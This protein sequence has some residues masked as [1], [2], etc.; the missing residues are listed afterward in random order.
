MRNLFSLADPAHSDCIEFNDGKI[1]LCDFRSLTEIN[2]DRLLE[3]VGSHTIDA[4]LTKSS[5]IGAVNW[6]KLVNVGTIWENIAVRLSQLGIPPKKVIFFMDLAE[7]EQRPHDDRLQLVDLVR[8]ITTQCHTILSFNLKEAWQMAEVF[9]GNFRGEKSPLKV[10]ELAAFLKKSVNADRIVIHP[11]DGAA[12]ASKDGCVYI[13][14]PFCRQPYI[15]I[16]AG[17]NFGAGCMAGALCGLDDLGILLTGVCTSGYFV[18]SGISPSYQQ[19]ARLASLWLEG[20]LPER[21]PPMAG[22]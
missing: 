7:F 3:C 2:W 18:R 6:G 19:I 5:F 17:D 12:C 1:M 9:Q 13:P 21:L 22:E 4:L 20:D 8:K 16:G 10:A 15:S 11:N 14:G